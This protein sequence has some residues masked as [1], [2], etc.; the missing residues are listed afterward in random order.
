[1]NE[2][3][4]L[5]VLGEIMGWTDA[6]ATREFAWLRLMSRMKYDG[7][8]DYL[9]GARFIESLADW[10]QQFE[11]SAERAAAYAFVRNWLVYIGPAEMLRLVELL[12]AD[13]VQQTLVRVVASELGIRPYLVWASREATEAY[14]RLLRR[15]LF[16]G[17]SDGARLDLFRRA[18]AWLISNEQIIVAAHVDDEKWD[19][20][21]KDLR[22]ADGQLADARFSIVYLID[23]FVG[24][25]T[26]FIRK[27]KDTGKWKGKL[28]KFHKT[29]ED[30]RLTHFEPNLRVRVHHYIAN[31]NAV[32]TLKERQAT[33]LQ[34]LGPDKWPSD[35]TFSFGT[36]LPE[37]LPMVRCDSREAVAFVELAKKYYDPQLE[38]RHTAEGR[39]DM[40]LGFAGCALPVIL[41][42]NT[43]NNSVSILWAETDGD[44]GHA[45]RPLFRRRQRHT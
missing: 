44:G 42:H 34:E 29:V 26:T 36:V 6:E 24:T 32:D 14:G 16:I 8:Q 37:N 43:P 30:K 23:D 18:N 15:T 5:R 22:Q 40:R 35:V 1:V 11:T 7:Y 45:M 13:E 4:A 28:A 33:A 31:H 41:E 12:Y 21:L 27:D 2:K 3:L 9:A 19:D 10:V 38:T 39:T 25:G 20:L 17:L